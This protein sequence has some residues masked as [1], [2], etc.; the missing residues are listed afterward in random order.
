MDNVPCD[1]AARELDLVAAQH[2]VVGEKSPDAETGQWQTGLSEPFD[3][4]LD[5]DRFWDSG[6][7]PDESDDVSDEEGTGD[8]VEEDAQEDAAGE[9]LERLILRLVNSIPLAD[10]VNVRQKCVDRGA[11][12]DVAE[13]HN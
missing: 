12:K 5:G 3:Q 6:A 4:L 2:G 7:Y 1:C 13:G 11:L 8:E 10:G 9:A